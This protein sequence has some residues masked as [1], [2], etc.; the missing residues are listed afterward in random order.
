MGQSPPQF[1]PKK[2]G[3][4][5]RLRV[6]VELKDTL[7]RLVSL[8][9][10]LEESEASEQF[11]QALEEKVTSWESELGEDSV[12]TPSVEESRRKETGQLIALN[13]RLAAP[14]SLKAP[15]TESLWLQIIE[16]SQPLT[17]QALLS[18][19]CQL[20]A[21]EAN[22]AVIQ[23]QSQKLEP[24]L[25]GKLAAIEAIF[26]EVT[27]QAIQVQLQLGQKVEVIKQK[28]TDLTPSQQKAMVSLEEFQTSPAKYF[29]LSGYAGTGKSYLMV[30]FIKK[31]KQK[32][33]NLI[34][35]T[36]TNKAA[37]NLRH[38][39]I[40]G[41]V[42]FKVMTIAS[43]LGQQPEINPETGEQE[44]KSDEEVDLSKYQ[45][46]IFDEFSMI[47]RSTFQEIQKATKRSKVQLIFVGDEAQLPPVG[48]SQPIIAT[49]EVIKNTANLREIVRYDGEI[50]QVAESIRNQPEERARLYPYRT[51]ADSSITCLS[52]PEW[53]E[54]ASQYLQSEAWQQNADYC[55]ILVWRN[56][57]AEQLNQW[58]REQLW[59][60]LAPPYVV[61][62]RLIAKKPVFRLA[63]NPGKKS[64]Y[65]WKIVMN[66]SEE[67][68]VIGAAKLR[69]SRE[70]EYWEVP[71]KTDDRFELSLKLLSPESEK[72]RQQ[73]LQELKKEKNWLRFYSLEKY[74]RL[75][76]LC[77]CLNYSQSSRK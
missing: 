34:A 43:L 69:K 22:R 72:K 38:L 53:L 44:F 42:N 66:N 52:R 21:C 48:E 71:V 17:T 74:R 4:T 23:L 63:G 54:L 27:G 14:D 30:R 40:S 32:G 39:A 10:S 46:L 15:E 76:P 8:Y 7:Q 73:K 1:S 36:P 57:T 26:Q 29:R 20:I 31:M 37:K 55:R 5:S 35:A 16:K 24:L 33:I 25:R 64:K 65:D 6:P 77:L 50:S 51:T 47:S 58:V 45:L 61:G 70:F 2:T 68:T 49:T 18:Q 9:E 12:T 62:E 75:L 28:T 11:L 41:G 67:C 13:R 59:G 19:H 3:Q 56:Q 60:Q